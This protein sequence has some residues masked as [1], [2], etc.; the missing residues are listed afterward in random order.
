MAHQLEAQCTSL[1]ADDVLDLLARSRHLIPI[2]LYNRFRFAA[3]YLRPDLEEGGWQARGGKVSC[4]KGGQ[5]PPRRN[6]PPP[7]RKH[8]AKKDNLR[9]TQSATVV[10]GSGFGSASSSGSGSS[11]QAFTHADLEESVK[12]VPKKVL[13]ALLRHKHATLL[14]SL[15]PEPTDAW[16]KLFFV[17]GLASMDA[18]DLAH[19]A[20]HHLQWAALLGVQGQYCALA[21][22]LIKAEDTTRAWPNLERMVPALAGASP[23]PY[24]AARSTAATVTKSGLFDWL[25]GDGG[26]SQSQVYHMLNCMGDRGSATYEQF[27][28]NSLAQERPELRA[29]SLLLRYE[30]VTVSDAPYLSSE[31]DGGLSGVLAGLSL[32]KPEPGVKPGAK[33]GTKPGAKPGSRPTGPQAVLLTPSKPKKMV[34]GSFTAASSSGGAG[35][36]Y[37]V[38]GG[39]GDCVVLQVP[40]KFNL[41]VD[42][43]EA[44]S[45]PTTQPALETL[46]ERS[47]F[48]ALVVTHVDDDHVGGC[49]SFFRRQR[50]K[51]GGMHVPLP[52][53][54]LFNTPANTTRG[55]KQGRMLDE[56][57][58]LVSDTVRHDAAVAGEHFRF[59]VSGQ[60]EKNL[61]AF[62]EAAPSYF[63]GIIISPEKGGEGLT[64]LN[65]YW[66]ENVDLSTPAPVPSSALEHVGEGY[67]GAQNLSIVNVPSICFV[68]SLAGTSVLMTGDA[69]S[70]CILDGLAAHWK[71]ERHF[72][73]VKVPHHGSANNSDYGFWL[74]VSGT[75]YLLLTDDSGGHG[76]PNLNVLL[77]II[78]AHFTR[79]TER[80]T[81]LVFSHNKSYDPS[82]KS[83]EA[84]TPKKTVADLIE[85]WKKKS[86]QAV[87][88]L[89]AMLAEEG[90]Y[91]ALR[92][93]VPNL[94]V[95]LEHAGTDAALA[96]YLGVDGGVFA[97]RVAELHVCQDSC[98]TS[99]ANYFRVC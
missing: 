94:P 81:V 15:F 80:Q 7:T 28:Q 76:H 37:V 75:F 8:S 96:G 53:V 62:A 93:T 95:S 14:E 71:G 65:T 16:K 85:K 99:M 1:D 40:G 87:A 24:N 89:K 30:R 46:L 84:H 49:I 78:F 59:T 72:D 58:K 3:E 79:K 17:P 42:M 68:G 90:A 83:G 4:M 56:E 69:H 13:D 44:S 43:G 21:E 23:P 29:W 67:H 31:E 33:P 88:A 22:G 36:V 61:G 27:C 52:G 70:K 50:K 60:Y 5:S 10:S 92:K 25:R 20:L 47:P 77:A 41:V 18:G 48:N 9:P 51:G 54:V 66:K 63:E 45:F 26:Y 98:D 35:H 2:G 57:L 82:P 55:V 74:Q 39:K 86:S 34:E 91:V 6:S 19:L 97:K 64:A 38:H 32:G 11:E 73:V 12:G